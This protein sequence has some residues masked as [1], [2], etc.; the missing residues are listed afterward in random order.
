MRG[1][2]LRRIQY[3]IRSIVQFRRVLVYGVRVIYQTNEQRATLHNWIHR[4]EPS[5]VLLKCH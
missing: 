4:R 2:Y 1:M 3:S 5:K